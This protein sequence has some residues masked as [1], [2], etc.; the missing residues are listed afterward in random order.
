MV[1]PDAVTPGNYAA[2]PD[3]DLGHGACGGGDAP[4]GIFYLLRTSRWVP[5]S[6]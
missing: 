6:N 1:L 2:E 4:V 3:I 5:K